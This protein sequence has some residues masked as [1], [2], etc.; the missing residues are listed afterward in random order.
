MTLFTQ[1]SRAVRGSCWRH[2]SVGVVDGWWSGRV[3][4][5][6]ARLC[7]GGRISL[8]CPSCHRSLEVL[9][10]TRQLALPSWPSRHSLG[11]STPG[12]ESRQKHGSW[13][14]P[15]GRALTGASQWNEGRGCIPRVRAG[16]EVTGAGHSS[17]GLFTHG[18][19]QKFDTSSLLVAGPATISTI[20][21]SSPFLVIQNIVTSSQ[22]E[23][24]VQNEL[25]NCQVLSMRDPTRVDGYSNIRTAPLR[26]RHDSCGHRHT[27]PTLLL[28]MTQFPMDNFFH[29]EQEQQFCTQPQNGSTEVQP[30]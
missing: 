3:A 18:P 28:P 29:S 30:W 10:R 19:S 13:R 9:V 11:P 27:L 16:L 14:L 21:P 12:E 15:A 23:S 17:A 8:P 1:S 5:T 4:W 26:C 25:R 24:R 7:C 2:D 6:T 20:S 22:E